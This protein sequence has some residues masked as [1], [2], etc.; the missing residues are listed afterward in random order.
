MNPMTTP[1][2]IAIVDDEPLIAEL[3]TA[4]LQPLGRGVDAYGT[5]AAFLACAHITRYKTVL[6]DLQLTDM[7]GIDLITALA[8]RSPEVHIVVVSGHEPRV[9]TSAKWHARLCG[10]RHCDM[11]AKPFTRDALLRVVRLSDPA[12]LP[13]SC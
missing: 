4:I 9:L 11:L 5:A 2:D 8:K 12:Q 6:V 3:I 10:I 1:H 13:L 7:P